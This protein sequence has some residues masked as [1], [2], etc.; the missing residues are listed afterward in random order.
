MGERVARKSLDE[1]QKI[2]IYSASLICLSLCE[3]FTLE[4]LCFEIDRL[5]RVVGRSNVF[6][7]IDLYCG[8]NVAPSLAVLTHK[9]VSYV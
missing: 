6:E 8:T 7:V 3:Y 1:I 2:S 4:C 9:N 5:F